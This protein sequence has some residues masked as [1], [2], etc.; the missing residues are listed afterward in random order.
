MVKN[1]DLDAYMWFW[2]HDDKI[3]IGVGVWSCACI[4]MLNLSD[5]KRTKQKYDI[6][7]LMWWRDKDG[8]VVTNWTNLCDCI[9]LHVYGCTDVK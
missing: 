5:D 2:V 9:N 7:D 3:I 1:G 8:D 6:N 4:K